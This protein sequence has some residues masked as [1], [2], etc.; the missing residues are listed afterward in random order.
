[1]Q[2]GW[3]APSVSASPTTAHPIL[4]RECT[5]R[6]HRAL[7]TG[8]D[9]ISI[10]AQRKCPPIGSANISATGPGATLLGAPGPFRRWR[11]RTVLFTLCRPEAV[12]P[13]LPGLQA[14]VS[15]WPAHSR[16]LITIFS[17]GNGGRCQ[18][19]Q[20]KQMGAPGTGIRGARRRDPQHRPSESLSPWIRLH[21]HPT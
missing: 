6:H 12:R 17:T 16:P 5:Y 15:M 21:I 1:M 2:L 20:V 19:K 18:V 14:I 8:A 3:F 13:S 4:H 9:A 11:L 10:E 7:R